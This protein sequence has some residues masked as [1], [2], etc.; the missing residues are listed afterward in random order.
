MGMEK[1]QHPECQISINIQENLPHCTTGGTICPWFNAWIPLYFISVESRTSSATVLKRY[2]SQKPRFGILCLSCDSLVIRWQKKLHIFS[3]A[4]ARLLQWLSMCILPLLLGCLLAAILF[5]NCWIPD[6][7]SSN[8]YSW[9][10]K[11]KKKTWTQ[12]TDRQ[13][14]QILIISRDYSIN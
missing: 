14:I 6:L 12:L 5:I 2:N 3:S 4:P 1:V 8:G 11:K 9:R 13:P 10:K 7:L